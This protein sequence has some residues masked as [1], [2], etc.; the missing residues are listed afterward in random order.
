MWSR[1]RAGVG[2]TGPATRGVVTGPTVTTSCPRRPPGRGMGPT[3]ATHVC[4]SP[5]PHGPGP[6]PSGPPVSVTVGT[7]FQVLLFRRSY[8]RSLFGLDVVVVGPSV[9]PPRPSRR[10]VST[11]LVRPS[12]AGSVGR[13]PVPGRSW[14][15]RSWRWTCVPL[16]SRRDSPPPTHPQTGDGDGVYG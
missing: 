14:G 16:T 10:P 4:P 6:S 15:S 12:S 5:D 9:C 11:D 8:G 3:R 13:H 7:D 1:G 2:A